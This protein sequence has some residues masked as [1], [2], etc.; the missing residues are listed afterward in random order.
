MGS[1]FLR[2]PSV[3]FVLDLAGV[4]FEKRVSRSAAELAYFLILTFF[5][6]LICLNALLGA[7]E[8]DLALLVHDLGRFLP[9]G[10]ARIIGD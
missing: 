5:P 7:V 9:G 2:S 4:Y 8:L 6:L 1:K 10:V 3:R